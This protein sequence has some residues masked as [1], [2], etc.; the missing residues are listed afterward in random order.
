MIHINFCYI[1][2]YGFKIAS[3]SDLNFRSKLEYQFQLG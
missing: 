3:T 2:V 1:Y